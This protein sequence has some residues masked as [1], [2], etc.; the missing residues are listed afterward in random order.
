M[1]RVLETVRTAASFGVRC[2]DPVLDE[3]VRAGLRLR[4]WRSSGLGPRLLG[5]RTASDVYALEGLPIRETPGDSPPVTRAFVVQIDD[6]ASRYQS[7]AFRVDLPMPGLFLSPPVS[8]PPTD[9]PPGFL[10]FSTPTR[11]VP[12][13]IATI[14]G[15][16]EDIDAGGPARHALIRVA[17]TGGDTFFGLADAAGRFAVLARYP[18][19]EALLGG[20]PGGAGSGGLGEATWPVTV[21]VFYRPTAHESLAGTTLPHY[22]SLLRQDPAE[23]LATLPAEGGTPQP[24][25][26]GELAYLE[27]LVL[28]TEG[29]SRLLIRPEGS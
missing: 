29:A 1:I 19:P 13:W 18:A 27:P 16:L 3:Q 15:E 28:R 11:R 26:T 7:A 21:R 14:H 9:V 20:S 17:I 24:D 23:I 12:T 25:W 8:S 5:F 6:L 22:T 4:A 2:W 10:L